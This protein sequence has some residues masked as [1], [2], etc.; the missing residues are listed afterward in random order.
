MKFDGFVLAKRKNNGRRTCR[1]LLQH[2]WWRWADRLEEPVEAC[3]M[4]ELFR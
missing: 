4:P 2:A 1:A 3:P